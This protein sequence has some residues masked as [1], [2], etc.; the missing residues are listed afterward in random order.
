MTPT[1]GTEVR[2]HSAADEWKAMAAERIDDE[3]VFW[4][5]VE[6]CRGG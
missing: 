2:W 1:A 3:T 4:L 5:V 6:G